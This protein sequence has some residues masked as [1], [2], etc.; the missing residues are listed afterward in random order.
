MSIEEDVIDFLGSRDVQDIYIALNFAPPASGGPAHVNIRVDSS[1]FDRV[2][3]AIHSR[4]ITIVEREPFTENM[5]DVCGVLRPVAGAFWRASN[6]IVIPRPVGGFRQEI[7][8]HEAVHVSFHLT[9]ASNV[10]D[11]FNEEATCYIAGHMHMAY[12]NFRYPGNPVP[13]TREVHRLAQICANQMLSS[14]GLQPG[15]YER[16]YDA[17]ANHPGYR[18]VCT[19]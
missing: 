17:I 9:R 12:N 11:Y 14:R 2:A 15:S 3:R 16:L 5:T 10:T 4:L 19:P 8:V 6:K 7:V 13:E 1:T 18:T